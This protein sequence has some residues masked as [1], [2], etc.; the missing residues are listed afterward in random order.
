L[1]RWQMNRAGIL[2][3]WYYTEEEFR[4][5]EGRLILRGTNGSG[6]SVTMQSFIPLVLD[7][8][9]RPERLDPFGSRD[10]RLEYYL[11]GETEQGHTDRTGYLW[12]E[13]YHPLKKLYKTIGIGLRARRGVP[14]IGFWG[15]LLEDG[16]RINH[17]FYLYDYHLWLEQ[18]KK[19]PLNRKLLEEKISSGGQVIQE[20]TAYRDMVNK[21]LF[22]FREHE[23]YKN[24]LKLLLELRSPKLSKD[25]KPSSIYDI[26]TKALPP[27]LEEELSSLSDLLEDMDQ[28]TDHL[29]ELRIHV[30]E[31]E[32]IEKCYDNY[33]RFLLQQHSVLVLQQG[34]KQD[35][36][37]NKVEVCER[38]LSEIQ[39]QQQEVVQELDKSRQRLGVVEAELD[40]LSRSEA[41]EKQRELE[42]LEEQQKGVDKHFTSTTGRLAV[43]YK[44]LE[45][46]QHEIAIA[47]DK[48]TTLSKD[49]GQIVTEL[50][51]LARIMEFREHDIYHGLWTRGIPTDEHWVKN[52]MKDL[53]IHKQRLLLAQKTARDE[54]EAARTAAEA[55]IR[56]GELYQERT[57]AEEEQSTQEEKL[58][59][60][61]ENLRE[62]IV[63]WQHALE[64]LPVDGDQLREVLRAVTL[65]SS[66]NRYYESVH[67][68]VLQAYEQQQQSFMQQL[69]QL[70]QQ[71]KL[72]LTDRQTLEQELEQWNAAKEPEPER[73]QERTAARKQRNRGSGAPLFAVC[74]FAAVLTE[75][76]RAQLEETLAQAGLLDA[77]ILPGGTVGLLEQEQEEEIWIEPVCQAQGDTL[78]GVLYPTPSPDSSLS[79]EDVRLALNSFAWAKN[80]NHFAEYPEQPQNWIIGRGQYRLGPLAGTN[81]SKPRAEYIGQETRLITKQLAIAQLQN[82]IDYITLEIEKVDERVASLEQQQQIMQ[83]E[84]AAFPDGKELQEQLDIL[85]QLSYRLSEIIKQEQK[86]EILYKQKT[87]I[88]RDLQIKLAEQTADWSRLK[89]EPEINEA[90]EL[91]ASYH[92][93]V[94]QLHSAWVRYQEAA[95]YLENHQEQQADLQSIVEEDQREQSELEGQQRKNTAQINQLRQLIAEMG[96]ADIHKQIMQCKEEKSSLNDTINNLHDR[97]EKLGETLGKTS[98]ELNSS[99]LQLAESRSVLHEF[100]E[101][102]KTEVRLALVPQWKENLGIMKDEKAIRQYCRQITK[103][104]GGLFVNITKERLINELYG[105]FNKA[106]VNLQEYVLEIENLDSGRIIITSKR[107]RMNPL[108]PLQLLDELTALENEQKV[109]LTTRDRELYEEIIIGSVGKAI[110][111]RI[112]RARDWVAQMDELM[113]QRDTSSGLRLSL[114]WVPLARKTEEEL[115]TETLVELLMRDAHRMDDEEIERVISHFRTRILRAK[116]DAQEEQGALRQHIYQ[117]LDYRTWFEF[118]LEH[119]KGEQSNYTE[120]TDSKF[121]VLSGGEKAM[122]MYIPLFA[123]TYSRYSDASEDAPKII[124]LDEAFAGVD[125]ANMRDMFKL[126]TNM[127]FDYIMTSQVL[128][129]CYDTVP[130]LAI[131]EIYRPKDTNVI[132]LFHYRW[133]GE[134]MLYDEQQQ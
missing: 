97:R 112:H 34:E 85:L 120:L 100:I 6:K 61:K 57:V 41:M 71:K 95:Q 10:R 30:D 48:L 79:E 4:F 116:Q 94:S 89:K 38:K 124:S 28:I 63:R 92:S 1:N 98:T 122:A 128:W 59:T 40:V 114:K 118:R 102:W 109:L 123:A 131:Y 68:P 49:Q 126:L 64:Q 110:R 56:L 47:E 96:I 9:K 104:Y 113:K 111:N 105:E 129:G 23:S 77:W 51:D 65:A 25:F 90:I 37:V 24:L 16:R 81:R 127:G 74:E 36:S 7:G 44:R 125:D 72:L 13:F 78:A 130:N 76:E 50:E 12:L 75:S 93:F 83:E 54:R 29:E 22:G 55:E 26:L 58:G 20:Q 31:L 60:V 43:N 3:F 87:S 62:N 15:F 119:R 42:L 73:R 91:C 115:D 19:V 107:D 133:N 66:K 11:L 39:G 45:R 132:T 52:W 82:K 46:L 106:K 69:L 134:R 67:R 21:S 33:N 53:D 27:L 35:Q 121:N 14:Q 2:N 86:A 108:T 117:L 18:G 88:W 32:K 17:D 84:L 70:E 80:E 8:D 99:Q 5:E 101:Q 103:E